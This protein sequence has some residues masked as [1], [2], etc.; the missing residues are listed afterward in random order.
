MAG[1]RKA[2]YSS[3]DVGKFKNVLTE[4]P[5]ITSQRLEK[6]HVLDELKADIRTLKESKGYD[7]KEILKFLSDAGFSDVTLR[8]I[9]DISTGRVRR[10]RN[11]A[12]GKPQQR[13][14]D[15]AADNGASSEQ[16]TD[17]SLTQ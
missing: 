12:S 17:G 5:D 4:L 7:D 14:D 1:K 6:K 15:K 13:S 8:D 10:S 3:E 16:R 2:F 11:P 9:K